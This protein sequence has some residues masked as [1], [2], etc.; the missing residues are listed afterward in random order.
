M[1]NKRACVFSADRISDLPPGVIQRILV[2]LPIKDAAKTSTLSSKWRHCW[3]SIPELVFD[4][5]FAQIPEDLAASELNVMNKG[6]MLNIYN[7]LL[8]HDGPITKF[9]LAILGLRPCAEIDH[10][11]LYLSNKG[12]EYFVLEFFDKRYKVHSSLF[13]ALHLETLKLWHCEFKPPSW[14]V[15]FSK[16]TYLQL[17]EVNL[18]YDFVENFLP[19]CPMLE[20]LMVI[21]C[22]GAV[23]K[24]EIMAPCLKSFFFMGYKDVC[25]MRSTLPPLVSFCPLDTATPNMASFFASSATLH[26]SYAYFLEQCLD[27]A[28]D[29]PIPEVEFMEMNHLVLYNWEIARIFVLLIVGFPNLRTLTVKLETS[30]LR[31]DQPA[32]DQNNSIRRVLEAEN[33]TDFLQHL[34]E[35]RIGESLCGPFELD[36]VTFVLLTA[37]RLRLIHIT[38]FHQLGSKKVI[39]FMKEVL[40]CRR[41][42]KRA[43]IVY[44]WNGGED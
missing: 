34:R 43:E 41:V 10:I 38:P 16:L 35:L 14:F 30:Q 31:D 37:P 8:V 26:Q 13:S 9:A 12:V 4:D 5:D 27:L 24:H 11:I 7:S 1:Q 40:K 32:N 19:K 44:D 39:R 23:G 28:D 25:F 6:I 42:S 33:C 18:P 2:F 22:Y 36:L 20:H 29:N 3:R 17:F 21:C 15:G